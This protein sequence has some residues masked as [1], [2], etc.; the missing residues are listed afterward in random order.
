MSP[1]QRHDAHTY[2]GHSR[3]TSRCVPAAAGLKTSFEHAPPHPA[4]KSA[5]DNPNTPNTE[6]GI[7]AKADR[8]RHRNPL[9]KASLKSNPLALPL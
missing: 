9:R 4:G 3:S 8:E 7:T 2:R 5:L 1:R 6:A